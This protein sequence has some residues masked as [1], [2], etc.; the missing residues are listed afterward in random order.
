MFY[1]ALPGNSVHPWGRGF[2]YFFLARRSINEVHVLWIT[3][4]LRDVT[5]NTEIAR[6]TTAFIACLDIDLLAAWM[7]LLTFRRSAHHCL[8]FALFINISC[9]CEIGG[10]DEYSASGR[11]FLA[12]C[13]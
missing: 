11:Q 12:V 4:R 10:F 3:R 2:P 7:V 5:G 13:P 6:M 9:S 1:R 8:K